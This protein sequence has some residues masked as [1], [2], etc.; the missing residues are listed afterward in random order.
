MFGLCKNISYLLIM[1][2]TI[3]DLIDVVIYLFL[4]ILNNCVLINE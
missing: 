2:N 4:L 1:P 3:S